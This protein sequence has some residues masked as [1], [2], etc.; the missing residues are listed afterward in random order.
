MHE[1]PLEMILNAEGQEEPRFFREVSLENARMACSDVRS[2]IASFYLAAGRDAPAW[3]S[4][5]NDE[6]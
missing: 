3:L 5:V 6:L 2:M 4:E 1:K